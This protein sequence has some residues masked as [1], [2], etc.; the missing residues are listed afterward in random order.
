MQS[1]AVCVPDPFLRH[2]VW[3][4]LNTDEVAEPN[5][6]AVPA[7]VAAFTQGE[8]W[9]DALREYISANRK[10]AEEF[11][12]RELPTLRVTPQDATYLLWIDASSVSPDGE[13]LAERI[14]EKTGLYLI[15]GEEY[16]KAG[17]GFLRMNIACPRA[18][19]LDGLA[20]L[21]KGVSDIG[22]RI[23]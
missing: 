17:K 11:I 3:R 14:R 1:A 18:T 9:L 7:A 2:K 19:L 23:S 21:K 5:A 15:G 16:G 13:A 10:T 12:G 22:Y 20:R 6:F 4:G 8:P